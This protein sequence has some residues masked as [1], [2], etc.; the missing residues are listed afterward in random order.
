M[1]SHSPKKRQHLV[2]IPSTRRDDEGSVLILALVFIVL[3]GI[4]C[5]LMLSY[6]SSNFGLSSGEVTKS[7]Q[8]YAADG[9]IQYAARQVQLNNG[10]SCPTNMSGSG[11]N[12]TSSSMALP[13]D[14]SGVNV[15]CQQFAGPGSNLFGGYALVAG[16]NVSNASPP[17]YSANAGGQSC[18]SLSSDPIGGGTATF[19]S[20]SGTCLTYPAGTSPQTWSALNTPDAVTTI[21]AVYEIDASNWLFAG[22]NTST[23]NPAM[24][25]SD[26]D[27]F[28]DA[29]NSAAL[30]NTTGIEITNAKTTL[31]DV[32]AADEDNVWAVG[33]DNGTAY[34]WYSSNL[35]NAETDPTTV[36]W[37]HTTPSTAKTL[38]GVYGTD[39]THV[40][41][42]G[43]TTAG[44][45]PGAVWFWNGTSWSAPTNLANAKNSTMSIHALDASHVWAI[46]AN[47]AAPNLGTVWFWN[48]TSWS[49]GT[50]LTSAKTVTDIFP[51]DSTHVWAVGTNTA[52]GNVGTVWFWNGTSWSSGT[53]IST[54][55]TL[56]AISGTDTTHIWTV[57]TS[58]AGGNP[59]TIWM[60][61]GTSW[62]TTGQV[63]PSSTTPA[64]NDVFAL[65]NTNGNPIVSA[66]GATSEALEY[67][68][69]TP[70]TC[71]STTPCMAQIMGGPVFNANG[72]NL[73]AGLQ[74]ANGNFTQVNTPTCPS[75]VTQ[76]SN[77]VIAA[78]GTYG[79]TTTVPASITNLSVALPTAKPGAPALGQTGTLVSVSGDPS[80]S[81]YRVFSPGT[82]TSSISLA[83][84]TT[85]FFESG[86]YNFEGGW[87]HLDNGNTPPDNLYVI[88]GKP[89]PGDAVTIASNSPC[90]NAIQSGA[91]W[92]G[93]SGTGVEF[94]LAKN[95]WWD[96][97]TVNLELFTREG[98][99]AS[100]GFQGLSFRDVSGVGSGNVWYSDLS[101][102]G[103]VNQ[104]FQVDANNHIPNVYVHGGIYAPNH[105]VVEYNNQQQVTLGP[106][107]ANSIELAY[108]T[109]T[110][111]Q[112][113]ISG[114]SPGQPIVV[115]TA[116]TG[117]VT[118]QAYVPF[119]SSGNVITDP[120]KGYTWRV[121]SPS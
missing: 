67:S 113:R 59:G 25:F 97:H 8:L 6:A 96:V 74:I 64:L 65:S 79:C 52:A 112:L 119:D 95:T 114:G 115:L 89:S 78:G 37:T 90:W 17:V 68:P 2:R 77:L 109:S 44:G 80:C 16:V 118:V 63:L 28:V 94:I 19:A 36:T 33:A 32:W 5:S 46:G 86:V 56:T 70:W 98:G 30:P 61:D 15:T 43:T 4:V 49:S 92:N 3:F 71:N 117:Q 91:Y 108:A 76:P 29:A 24:W 87:G 51:L 121:L 1:R 72:L 83:K 84:N 120:N 58:T 116:T 22:N 85:N 41:I 18:Q 26:G 75:P 81:S 14:V 53:T 111:P 31:N 62:S 106:M 11:L 57:G 102:L 34:V 42:V 60:W 39:A 45:N 100:E 104:I 88:G 82:Y 107:F 101:N 13:S 10:Q 21:A 12:L 55:K 93:G 50:T 7:H 40:W 105:N 48:G 110:T 66:V 23:H 35:P 47:T 20:G 38:T 69:I 99:A 54:A 103:G 73:A 27:E 9:A